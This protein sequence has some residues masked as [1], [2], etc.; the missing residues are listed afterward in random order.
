M[1]DFER[2]FTEEL[3]K[4][5]LI[6][7]MRFGEDPMTGSLAGLGIGAA[8][9]AALG[10]ALAPKHRWLGGILG[11]LAGGA[12]GVPIGGLAGSYLGIK[13]APKRF[14]QWLGFG[15]D[16]KEAPAPAPA[17]QQVPQAPMRQPSPL[18]TGF[19]V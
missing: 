8:G 5:A 19:N 16:K 9:G 7:P 11:G 2:G 4:I 15:K 3:E 6:G 18:V 17:Q 12:A 10:A 1:T 13:R 14:V